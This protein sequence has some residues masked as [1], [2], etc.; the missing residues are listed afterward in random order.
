MGDIGAAATLTP[1]PA[2][3]R[4]A[5]GGNQFRPARIVPA[6]R[7]RGK[8]TPVLGSDISATKKDLKKKS[9]GKPAVTTNSE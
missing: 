5:R 2:K 6:T 8:Q 7:V 4:K 1:L 9:S 3:F